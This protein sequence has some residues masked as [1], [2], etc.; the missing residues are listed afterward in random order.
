MK[1]KNKLEIT[2]FLETFSKQLRA[3]TM[4]T[5]KTSVIQKDAAALEATLAEIGSPSYK[6]DEAFTRQ[7]ITERKLK[8]CQAAL[9]GQN[10][11]IGEKIAALAELIERGGRLVAGVLKDIAS[12]RQETITCALLPF[13]SSRARAEY[14]A[15]QTDACAGAWAR[16]EHYS[17]LRVRKYSGNLMGSDESHAEYAE[18]EGRAVL[19]MAWEIHTVLDESVSKTPDLLKYI[20]FAPASDADRGKAPEASDT[21]EATDEVAEGNPAPSPEVSS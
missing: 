4:A 19:R 5:E 20:P 17:Q 14:T 18:R 8:S 6:D 3:A 1:P 13:S 12:V 16:V 10:T 15:S 21:A 9:E 11:K 7:V 2:E